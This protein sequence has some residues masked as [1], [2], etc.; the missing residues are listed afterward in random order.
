VFRVTLFQEHFF[1]IKAG[2]VTMFPGRR[3]ERDVFEGGGIERTA[4]IAAVLK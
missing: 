3:G 4:I 2:T 1:M